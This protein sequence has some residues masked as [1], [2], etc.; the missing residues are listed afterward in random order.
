MQTYYINGIIFSVYKVFILQI[1]ICFMEVNIVK[2]LN[3]FIFS[4]F[5]GM[6]RNAL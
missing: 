4:E 3:S 2:K 6:E 5:F 1:T